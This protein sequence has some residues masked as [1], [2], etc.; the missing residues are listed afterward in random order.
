MVEFLISIEAA[1][2]I[3]GNLIHTDKTSDV[4]GGLILSIGQWEPLVVIVRGREG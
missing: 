1:A 2:V 3:V 4:E